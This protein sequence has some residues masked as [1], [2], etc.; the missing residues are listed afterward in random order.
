MPVSAIVIQSEVEFMTALLL[1]ASDAAL[2]ESSLHT[3][4]GLGLRSHVCATLADS[5]GSPTEL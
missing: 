5:P 2:C 4:T 3:Q 1:E